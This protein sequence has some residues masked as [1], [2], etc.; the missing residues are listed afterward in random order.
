MSANVNVDGDLEF[1]RD[2]GLKINAGRVRPDVTADDVAAAFADPDSPAS[3]QLSNAVDVKI[4]GLELV[5]AE[6]TPYFTAGAGVVGA[7]A[8]EDNSMIAKVTADGRTIGA[9]EVASAWPGVAFGDSTTEASNVPA[10]TDRWVNIL[11]TAIGQ[12]ITNRGL[13]GA[14]AE[15]II[16]R[17][18]ALTINGTVTSIPASGGVNVTGLDVDPWQAGPTA[19]VSVEV[20]TDDGTVVPGT[21]APSGTNRVFTRTTAGTAITTAR[22]LIRAT[23]QTTGTLFLGLG[24]NNEPD[25][26]AGTLTVEQVKSWY[27][28]A[29]RRHQG[30]LIVWG[31]LDRG[32]SEKAGTVIGDFIAELEAWMAATFGD[33]YYP[34][35]KYLASPQALT[36]AAIVQ[37]GFTPTTDDTAAQTDKTVPPSFR[38]S[39]T[40]V[41]LKALGQKLQA[42]YLQRQ[43]RLRGALPIAPT[44]DGQLRV[45]RYPGLPP[46]SGLP[47]LTPRGILDTFTRP[48][49]T[50]TLGSTENGLPWVVAAGVFGI[51]AGSAYSVSGTGARIAYVEGSMSDGTFDVDIETPADY[52]GIMF[53]Y[54][55]VNNH[56]FVQNMPGGAIGL[57]KRVGGASTQ[58]Q[59]VS[60]Q[61]AVA[62]DRLTVVLAG[63][64]VIVKRNGTTIITQTV[65]DLQTATKFGFRLDSSVFKASRFS[66][67]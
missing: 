37:P 33:D 6:A 44:S 29:A 2:S 58:V 47:K 43:M 34:V 49:S 8:F 20:I 60:A 28:M 7:F 51:S 18:G 38:D 22:I 24:I 36:D 35:R 67:A 19:G 54:V 30:R 65:T 50:T 27:S 9:S 52:S 61:G 31:V 53:R 48:D 17:A 46:V 5:T 57:W 55:D 59:G 15:E 41:H 32:P 42:R 63:S 3:V 40:S 26:V 39:P 13:S 64:S 23:V 45:W 14:R 21:F 11:S 25:I 1:T 66:V 12:T 4:D 16:F 56:L 62:G 10:S